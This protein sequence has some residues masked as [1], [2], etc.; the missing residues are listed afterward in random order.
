MRVNHRLLGE[1]E[2]ADTDAARRNYDGLVQHMTAEEVGDID[3]TM[4]T[5]APEPFWVNHGTEVYLHGHQAVR[6]RYVNRFRDEP[7]MRVDID[8]TV[9]LDSAAVMKGFSKPGR[10]RRRVPLVIWLEFAD[11]HVLG[12]ASYSNPAESSP[13]S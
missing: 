6:T 7:G 9:V 11:G 2:I 1:V 13:D 3:R 5:M 4:A 8:H 10:D 12:E